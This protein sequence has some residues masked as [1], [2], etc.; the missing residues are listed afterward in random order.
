MD[1]KEEESTEIYTDE[2]FQRS[3]GYCFGDWGLINHQ[4]RTCSVYALEDTYLFSLNFENFE[5]TFFKCLQNSD[6]QKRN[7]LKEN[8][9]PFPI[10]SHDYSKIL[11]NNLIPI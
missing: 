10:S 5:K 6:Q 9:F 3:E 8:L 4:N 2:L 7:F 1:V 11:Y